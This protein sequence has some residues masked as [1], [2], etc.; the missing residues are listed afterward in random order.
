MLVLIFV[1]NVRL[2]PKASDFRQRRQSPLRVPGHICGAAKTVAIRSP[3]RRSQPLHKSGNPLAL[4]RSRGTQE[5]DGRQPR[6]LL[7]ARRQRP[8]RC[9]AAEQRDEVASLH[10]KHGA[11]P[12]SRVRWVSLA[13]GCQTGTAVSLGRNVYPQKHDQEDQDRIHH[14]PH[15]VGSP[16]PSLLYSPLAH[17]G[18]SLGSQCMGPPTQAATER[19]HRSL[20]QT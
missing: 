3:R 5:P 7:S 11:L 9:R 13:G 1:M 12:A 2:P 4:D 18:F 14:D 20:G 16:T 19:M 15:D 8:R 6:R 17:G 10:V